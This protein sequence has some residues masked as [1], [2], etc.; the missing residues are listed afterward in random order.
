MK[1]KHRL[2]T[3]N[4]AEVV[5]PKSLNDSTLVK[6][7][8]SIAV[9][10]QESYRLHDGIGV[11]GFELENIVLENFEKPLPDPI[12]LKIEFPTSGPDPPENRVSY[13]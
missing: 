6:F 12:P 10:G 8:Q 4:Y 5:I 2:Y 7:L 13:Q 3:I 11:S 9:V 1:I